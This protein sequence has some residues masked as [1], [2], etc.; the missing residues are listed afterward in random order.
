MATQVIKKD[1]SKQPFDVEKIKRAIEGAA[2]EAG[3]PEERISQ[4][5]REVS[6][7]VISQTGARDDSSEKEIASSEIKAMILNELD[8]VDPS[9]SAAWRTYEASK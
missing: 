4:V 1:G 2:R 9:V 6:E 7:A 8:R 5:V 3:L